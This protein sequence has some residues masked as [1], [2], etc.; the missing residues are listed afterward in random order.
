[1]VGALIG[2][3][4]GFALALIYART[5]VSLKGTMMESS[6]GILTLNVGF[7]V[8]DARR[9]RLARFPNNGR[10]RKTPHTKIVSRLLRLCFC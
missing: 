9:D 7:P 3:L 8:P 10:S 1:M 5:G 6:W 2:S 4:L